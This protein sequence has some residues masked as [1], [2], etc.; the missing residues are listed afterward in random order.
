MKPSGLPFT[1]E[2]NTERKEIE[3]QKEAEA[4]LQALSSDQLSNLSPMA[5]SLMF[6]GIKVIGIVGRVKKNI[7]VPLSCC[8]TRRQR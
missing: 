5:S 4:I 2:L 8:R 7:T 3:L 1:D 6:Y